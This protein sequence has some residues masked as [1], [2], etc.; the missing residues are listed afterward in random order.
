M[1]KGHFWPRGRDDVMLGDKIMKICDFFHRHQICRLKII[2]LAIFQISFSYSYR[3]MRK[4]YCRPRGVMTSCWG[5]RYWKFTISFITMEFVISK[6]VYLQIFKFLS[7]IVREWSK[8]MAGRDRAGKQRGQHF[9]EIHFT[10]C[11]HFFE[12]YSIR[13]HWE[14]LKTVTNA[15]TTR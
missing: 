3:D 9:F 12:I 15:P 8:I 10:R 6:L 7:L 1:R 11:R 13:G 14:D 5:T 4:G 2:L